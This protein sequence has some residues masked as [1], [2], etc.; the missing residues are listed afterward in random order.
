MVIDIF[1]L[2]RFN[3]AFSYRKYCSPN[4]LVEKPYDAYKAD[5]YAAGVCLF[6]MLTGELFD[7]SGSL[8]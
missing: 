3:E 4:I 8:R 2:Y 6:V 1:I 7:V 5:W